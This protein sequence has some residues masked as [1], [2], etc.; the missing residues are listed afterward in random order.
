MIAPQKA[1]LFPILALAWLTGALCEPIL[2][3]LGRTDT[4]NFRIYFDPETVS[5]RAVELAREISERDFRLV[6]EFLG[7]ELAHSPVVLLLAGPGTGPDGGLR[8]PR[9]DAAGRILLYRYT[10]RDESYFTPLPHELVHVFRRENHSG[11]WFLEEAFASYVSDQVAPDSP[12][13]PV[14]GVPIDVVAGQWFVRGRGHLA[15]AASRP[16]PE[17]QHSLYGPVVLVEALLLSLSPRHVRQDIP[18]AT[19]LRLVSESRGP[20][21]GGVRPVARGAGSRLAGPISPQ[22]YLQI[23]RANELAEFY[24]TRT[25]V[26]GWTI[27]R[28]GE[29]F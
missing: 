18:D 10:E 26:A 6:K 11:D 5:D 24:R 8:I 27:C 2:G 28:S 21:P 23:E 17:A 12:G 4:E 25:P 13:F 9:V 7:D 29:D 22:R 14:F 19:G 3:A 20:F 1:R 16:T 15:L